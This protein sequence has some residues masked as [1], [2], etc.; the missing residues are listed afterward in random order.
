ME[1][2]ENAL[3]NR[4]YVS[5]IGLFV[6]R[7][8]E[9]ANGTVCRMDFHINWL[10]SHDEVVKGIAIFSP[11]TRN[12]N[13][14]HMHLYTCTQTHT[15]THRAGTESTDEALIFHFQEV[16]IC[17]L[18]YRLKSKITNIPQSFLW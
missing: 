12:S 11:Q 15:Q 4:A 17:V 1:I 13:L 14:I 18:A 3:F 6:G 7:R 5:E 8:G 16:S 2:N 9:G 10:C